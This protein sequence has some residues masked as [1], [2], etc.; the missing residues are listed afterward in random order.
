MNE[1]LE[2]IATAVPAKYAGQVALLLVLSQ[3][4]GRMFH[5]LRTGGGLKALFTSVWL[6][7][8]T[9]RAN[10]PGKQEDKRQRHL[11]PVL[12]AVGLFAVAGC[13][14]TPEEAVYKTSGTTHV[15]AKAALAAWN[16]Y[17][18]VKDVSAD[19]EREVKRLWQRYQVAQDVLLSSAVVY[20][21]TKSPDAE[22]RLGKATAA[23]GEALAALVN[24]LRTYGVKLE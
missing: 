4:L 8:N 12:L 9:P 11:F 21:E 22:E 16:D 19:K 7:T 10:Q 5:A 3:V 24:L 2:P 13:N 15:T 17:L 6:G 23:A 20:A 18:A 14:T 1:I